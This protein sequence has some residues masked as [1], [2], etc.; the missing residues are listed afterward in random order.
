MLIHK[1]TFH[2]PA[3]SGI[4]S[5]WVVQYWDN[6]PN[7]FPKAK[8]FSALEDAEKFESTLVE[9]GDWLSSQETPLAVQ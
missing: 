1:E 7:D 9:Y 2:Q 8:Y 6:D 4:P 3:D 5:H